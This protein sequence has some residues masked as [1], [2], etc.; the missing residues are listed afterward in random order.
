MRN[1]KNKA[2]TLIELLVVIAII[3]LLLSIA[4]PALRKAKEAAMNLICK[5]N[6]RAYGQAGNAYLTENANFLPPSGLTI[7]NMNNAPNPF[8]C[9]WHNAIIDPVKDPKYAGAMIPHLSLQKNI[10]L[11]PYFLRVA[12]LWGAEHPGHDAAVPVEPKYSYSVNAYLSL[13]H[14]PDTDPLPKEL[15]DPTLPISAVKTPARTFFFAEENPWATP[16]RN[17][18]TFNDTNLWVVWPKTLNKSNNFGPNNAKFPSNLD[19]TGPFADA[20]A[21]F[22]STSL[23]KSTNPANADPRDQGVSNAVFLDGHVEVVNWA[24]SWRFQKTK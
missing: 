15:N 3:A 4:V 10:H 7:F 22:H 18:N 9:R 2:F 5:T 16:T 24:D 8:S 13:P 11:C 20:F 17:E 14:T 6:L 12:K 21:T 23:V 19:G 1:R